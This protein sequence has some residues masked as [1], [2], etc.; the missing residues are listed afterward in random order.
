MALAEWPFVH[1]IA[2]ELLYAGYE[3]TREGSDCGDGGAKRVRR[4]SVASVA[5]ARA[6]DGGNTNRDGA[7]SRGVW[8]ND[9]RRD[10]ARLATGS[11][12]GEPSF[13]SHSPGRAVQ[14]SRMTLKTS[15][16]T[17]KADPKNRTGLGKLI[18]ATTY[19]PTQLP[20]QYHRPCE[21]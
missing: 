7:L 8:K 15:A 6:R 14:S 20:V 2:I 16:K 19:V 17:K 12:R 10:Y 3:A 4:A 13:C 1:S 9:E 18:P 11:V 5:Y 21:A